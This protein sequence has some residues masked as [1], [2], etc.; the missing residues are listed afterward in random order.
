MKQEEVEHTGWQFF[1]HDLLSCL[2]CRPVFILNS[3]A[4]PPPFQL[5]P[6]FCSPF[7][8]QNFKKKVSMPIFSSLS[9]PILKSTSDRI[10]FLST[11]M[12]QIHGLH[13]AKIKGH[14]SVL[15]SLTYK[16]CLIQVIMPSF[17]EHFLHL[18][19]R[20]L[21]VPHFLLISLAA[22][23]YSLIKFLIFTSNLLNLENHKVQF[24]DSL[25]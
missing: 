14:L 4:F 23:F 16:L 12:K 7:E 19:S 18:I 15:I 8:K 3:M 11:L 22:F 9:F 20:T 6:F 13:V 24:S 21:L 2:L 1:P 25:P 10:L 17:L 5:L